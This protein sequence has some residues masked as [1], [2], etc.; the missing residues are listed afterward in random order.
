[1]GLRFPIAKVL[2]IHSR[3]QLLNR[4]LK[5]HQTRHVNFHQIVFLFPTECLEWLECLVSYYLAIK[6]CDGDKRTERA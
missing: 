5:T 2:V 1:M 4:A 3:K 6:L